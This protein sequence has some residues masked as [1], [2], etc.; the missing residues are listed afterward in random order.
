M[1]KEVERVRSLVVAAML[2]T[3]PSGEVLFAQ[4]HMGSFVLAQ[5]GV[6]GQNPPNPEKVLKSVILESKSN[7]YTL[8][9]RLLILVIGMG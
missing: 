9:M 2:V 1:F 3:W 7:K 4:E 6:D 5:R 8:I